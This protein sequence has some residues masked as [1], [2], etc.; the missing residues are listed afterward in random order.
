M[1]KLNSKSKYQWLNWKEIAIWAFSTATLVMCLGMMRSAVSIDNIQSASTPATTISGVKITGTLDQSQI[2]GIYKAHVN[3]E[4]ISGKSNKTEFKINLVKSTFTGNPLSRAFNAGDFKREIVASKD[5][6]AVIK[7]NQI[8]ELSFVLV[9][10][11]NSDMVTQS[12][13]TDPSK[14]ISKELRNG[15]TQSVPSYSLEVTDGKKT[16]F[17][18]SPKI[19]VGI[20]S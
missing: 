20:N 16:A 17:L 3:V 15:V 6:N 14:P 19:S 12:L 18:S 13:S 7:N 10:K 1:T 5:I 4:N 9:D 11:S 2:H 8:K